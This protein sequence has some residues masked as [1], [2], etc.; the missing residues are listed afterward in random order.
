METILSLELKM[1]FVFKMN[2]SVFSIVSSKS[3]QIQDYFR[4][5]Y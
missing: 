4:G 3:P 5:I 2:L 1:L